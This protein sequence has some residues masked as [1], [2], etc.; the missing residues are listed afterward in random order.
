MHYSD[1]S[2]T[3]SISNMAS[4]VNTTP[5]AISSS[6]VLNSSGMKTSGIFL[7][8]KPEISSLCLTSNLC[9]TNLPL[10]NNG[11]GVESTN[12]T[13]TFGL[14]IPTTANISQVQSKAVMVAETSQLQANMS[15]KKNGPRA[16][17]RKESNNNGASELQFS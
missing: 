14:L 9:E 15:S 3:V 7:Q 4:N 16:K 12:S 6:P 5:S 10:I 8:E 11:K 1:C 17:Q 13:K 2:N